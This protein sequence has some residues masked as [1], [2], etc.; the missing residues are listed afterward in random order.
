MYDGIGEVRPA[1]YPG[2]R[3]FTSDTSRS[4]VVDQLH[5]VGVFVEPAAA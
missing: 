4:S 2:G 5:G 1:D 3:A